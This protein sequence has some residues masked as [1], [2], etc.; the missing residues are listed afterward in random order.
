MYVYEIQKYLINLFKYSRRNKIMKVYVA[1]D[2]SNEASVVF[3]SAAQDAPEIGTF[4]SIGDIADYYDID[5]TAKTADDI[6]KDLENNHNVLVHEREINAERYMLFCSAERTVNI[7]E[8]EVYTASK[9]LA[10]IKDKLEEAAKEVLEDS[11][12]IYILSGMSKSAYSWALETKSSNVDDM[13]PGYSMPHCTS[14]QRI[15]EYMRDYFSGVPNTEN[16]DYFHL[17]SEMFP[18]AII[19]SGDKD[20]FALFDLS[21]EIKE[22]KSDKYEDHSKIMDSI[23]KTIKE[24][25]KIEAKVE[26]SGVLSRENKQ[27]IQTQTYKLLGLGIKAILI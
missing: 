3:S 15:N 11:R 17:I 4:N 6:I 24:I 5:W 16:V 9:L 1:V 18:E 10:V 27:T 19:V 26:I 20:K 8:A 22:I 25:N 21:K 2:N 13:F 12:I 14:R 23:E 7:N